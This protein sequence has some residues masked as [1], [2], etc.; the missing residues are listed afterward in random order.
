GGGGVE[1]RGWS[2]RGRRRTIRVGACT[3]PHPARAPGRRRLLARSCPGDCFY[4]R[5]AL[6]GRGAVWNAVGANAQFVA[7]RSAACRGRCAAEPLGLCADLGSLKRSIGLTALLVR[8]YDEAL[9]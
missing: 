3:R 4:G 2:G 7:D 1:N 8:D 9:E 5:R 6:P